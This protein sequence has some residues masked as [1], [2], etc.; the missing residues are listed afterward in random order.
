M[1][2]IG[3]VFINDDDMDMGVFSRV[4][5]KLN[6][7][8]AKAVIGFDGKKDYPVTQEGFEKEH[9]IYKPMIRMKIFKNHEK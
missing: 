6:I 5:R 4:C 8:A 7:D 2:P 1:F 9:I 3:C